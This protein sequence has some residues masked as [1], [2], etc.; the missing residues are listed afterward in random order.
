MFLFS[1]EFYGFFFEF[2]S[3][4]IFQVVYES[5]TLRNLSNSESTRTKDVIHKATKVFFLSCCYVK[6]DINQFNIF[7][8]LLILVIFIYWSARY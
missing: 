7:H 2:L 3:L 5:I 4:I 1:V 6:F 8:Y